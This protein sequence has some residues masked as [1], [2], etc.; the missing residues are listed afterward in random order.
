MLSRLTFGLGVSNP[1][2]G[3][4]IAA[5]IAQVATG[6]E[7]ENQ[8]TRLGSLRMAML[9]QWGFEMGR[10]NRSFIGGI[11]LVA[12]AVVPV[13]NFPTTTAPFVLYNSNPAGGKLYHVTHAG[14][15]YGSGTA[16]AAGAAL[17]GG[18]TASVLATALTSN[19]ATNFQT[20]S[21][22]GYGAVTGYVGVAKTIPSGSAWMILS[23]ST[24]AT[25]ATVTGPAVSVD[26]RHMGF[27]VP[28]GYAMVLGALGDTGTSAKYVFSIAWN[29]IDADLL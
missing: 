27:I 4:S 17:F 11:D 6:T 23:P 14:M 19:D 5:T 1:S 16:G 12:G 3:L 13:V 22:R 9:E 18:V 24:P 20:Q 28:P 8:I 21:T 26:V 10:A 29:E 15:A 25:A 2:S 7:Q